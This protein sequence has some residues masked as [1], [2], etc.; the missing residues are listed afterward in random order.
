MN[1]AN[2]TI[3]PFPRKSTPH[4]LSQKNETDRDVDF[5]VGKSFYK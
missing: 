2:L 5:A 3:F 1:I 4:F